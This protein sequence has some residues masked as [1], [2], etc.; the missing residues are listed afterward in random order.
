MAFVIGGL[1]SFVGFVFV[2]HVGRQLVISRVH[3]LCMAY[4]WSVSG[5]REVTVIARQKAHF[6]RINWQYDS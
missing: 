4:L 2:A 3:K 5:Q 6:G 1:S